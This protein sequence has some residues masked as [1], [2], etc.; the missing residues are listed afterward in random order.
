MHHYAATEGCR[1]G[2]VLV[3]GLKRA[4]PASEGGGGRR[5][6][7][8][9]EMNTLTSVAPRASIHLA[10]SAAGTRGASSPSST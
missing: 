5:R 3:A 2:V 8:S 1:M 9:G 6:W 4:G 7:A 10:S